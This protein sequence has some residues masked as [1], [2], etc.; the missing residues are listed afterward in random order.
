M[1]QAVQGNLVTGGDKRSAKG[2]VGW[3]ANRPM[4]MKFLMVIAVGALVAAG[5]GVTGMLGMSSMQ[6]KRSRC[7]RRAWCRSPSSTVIAFLIIALAIGLFLSRLVVNAVTKVG[8]VVAALGAGDL[9]RS[10]GVSSRD[11]IGRMAT[12]LDDATGRL[13]ESFGVATASQ[14]TSAGVTESRQ[15]ANEVARMAS[16]LQQVVSQFTV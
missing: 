1:T 15:A 13:R 14:L 7:T 10:A 11:E 3:V 5:V 8:A 2:L 6:A 16:E 9:T 12:A 4:R